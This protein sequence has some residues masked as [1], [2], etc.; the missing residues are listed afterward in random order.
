[1]THI[2]V[3]ASNMFFRARHVV[4]GDDPETKVGMAYHIMFASINKV[5]RDLD[6]KSTRLNSSH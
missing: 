4:R 1:M 3:D 6:R 2:L 5:W